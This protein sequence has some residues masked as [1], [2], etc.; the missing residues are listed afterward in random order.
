[1]RVLLAVCTGVFLG[2]IDFYIVS[3]A[4]PDLL[5]S[6]SHAGIAEISWVINGY[7]ITY[8]A[9]LLPAGGLADRFGRRKIFLLGL[10]LFTLSALACAAAPTA[11]VLIAARCVQG[12]GGGT[13][14]PL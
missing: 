9:A 5:R 8:L 14:T 7:A 4:V 12:I 3:I 1:M 10:G 13:I 6:F 11:L 2:A